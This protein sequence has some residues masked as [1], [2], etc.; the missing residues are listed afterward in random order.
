MAS[1]FITGGA[2]GIGAASVRKFAAN[3]F[4]VAVFDIN[5][6]AVADL[7]HEGHSGS[8]T[9]F[10]TDVRQRSAVR[11]SIAAAAEQLG[12]PTALFV[13]AGIQKLAGIFE[14]EDED[15]DAII[16]IN[17]KGALYTVAEAAALMRDAGNGGTIVLMA[18]DQA[19]IGK[20]GSIV[21]GATK[22][23]VA[24]MAKSLSMIKFF[25]GSPTS[26]FP[27]IRTRRG[28]RRPRRCRSAGLLRRKRSPR[29]CIFSASRRRRL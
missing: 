7:A 28:R 19:L 4:D 17:L 5:A 24:Q 20:E 25:S 23:A 12:A 8:I 2:T 1:V 14:M 16:D 26:I 11:Q 13:N 3:G 9:Y 22:G 18:S 21:Y 10:E 29:W 15:I 27:A 6:Q